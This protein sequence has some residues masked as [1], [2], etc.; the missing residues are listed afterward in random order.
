MKK[1][2]LIATAI[3]TSVLLL[4]PFSAKATS[5]NIT[6][7]TESTITSDD[8]DNISEDETEESDESIEYIDNETIKDEDKNKS[9]VFVEVKMKEEIGTTIDQTAL[10]QGWVT[11]VVTIKNTSYSDN[12]SL[13]F[14]FTNNQTGEITKKTFNSIDNFNGG[15]LKLPY[16]EYTVSLE[17]P[18]YNQFIIYNEILNVNAAEQKYEISINSL[19]DKENETEEDVEKT[20]VFVHLLKNNFFFLVILVGCGGFLLYREIKRRQE[21]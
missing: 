6:V 16:G 1:I 11:F 8:I 20:N 13:V 14:L 15:T 7:E 3:L 5:E 19:V 4:V 21:N 2:S 17:D 9:N 18:Y 10:T 12:I